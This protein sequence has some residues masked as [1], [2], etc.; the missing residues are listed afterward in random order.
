MASISSS[1]KAETEAGAKRKRPG[2]VYVSTPPGS[3]NLVT[4]RS[5][6][7]LNIE[8]VEDHM[9]S[10]NKSRD[11]KCKLHYA[12][13]VHDDVER[14]EKIIHQLFGH[15]KKDGDTFGATHGQIR[16]A[17]EFAAMRCYIVYDRKTP[18]KNV[19]GY[20][21]AGVAESEFLANRG[22]EGFCIE[23][24]EAAKVK[25]GKR[26]KRCERCSWLRSANSRQWRKKKSASDKAKRRRKG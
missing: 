21:P 6:K 5:T 13:R 15:V 9:D 3:Q 4:I 22:K 19:K 26:I 12:M 20:A 25:N 18:A 14:A 10:L 17:M 2:I 11:E 23:C 24:G 8:A 1:K 16:A 7:S